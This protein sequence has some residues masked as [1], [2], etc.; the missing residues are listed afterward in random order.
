MSGIEK[1]LA[2]FGGGAKKK[3]QE[4]VQQPPQKLVV[5]PQGGGLAVET[6][7]RQLEIDGKVHEFT[8]RQLCNMIRYITQ[9][10][11]EYKKMGNLYA[12]MLVPAMR[13]ARRDVASLLEENFSIVWELDEN[14][15]SVFFV[16]S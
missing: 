1:A 8:P 11:G 12:V 13:K 14:G 2:I 5:R 6:T 10:I 9:T 7:K 4:L 15:D 16:S 3:K